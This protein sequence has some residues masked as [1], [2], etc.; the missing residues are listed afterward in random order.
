MNTDN[1]PPQNVLIARRMLENKKKM[2]KEA[3]EHS[4]TV[5][6]QQIKELLIKKNAERG[7]KY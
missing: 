1:T 3:I 6:F 5:E 4:K 2:Q 7:I